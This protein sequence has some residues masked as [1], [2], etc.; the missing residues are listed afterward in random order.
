MSR[1][2]YRILIVDDE[3]ANVYLLSRMLRDSYH[4][5][6]ARGGEEA[7]AIAQGPDKPALI[8]LD[9]MMPEIDGF[10]VCRR[11]KADDNTKDIIV[12]FVT[13]IG[14]SAAEEVG[15]KLGAADYITKPISLPI[16]RARVRNQINM[17]QKADMLEAMSYID[18]LTHVYNRRKF[19]TLL[20]KE[21]QRARLSGKPLGLIMIDFDHF[22]ALND[23]YGHGAGDICLQQGAAALGS[24]LKRQ[25]DLLARYGG[26]EFVALL[27]DTDLEGARVT[28]E[29]MR[30][31]V[32]ELALEH[33][34]S[35]AANHVTVSLG[36]AAVRA[37]DAHPATYLLELADRALNRAKSSGRDR[38]V[39][40][41]EKLDA[42]LGA[43]DVAVPMRSE[44]PLER[45]DSLAVT[46]AGLSP[47]Q[48][49][50]LSAGP[51]TERRRYGARSVSPDEIPQPEKV[52]KALSELYVLPL[53]AELHAEL[54]SLFGVASDLI[55]RLQ[56]ETNAYAS[57][58]SGTQ[59]QADAMPASAGG[60]RTGQL[61]A[62]PGA[63]EPEVAGAD[64]ASPAEA[65]PVENGGVRY[66]AARLIAQDAASGGGDERFDIAEL[67]RRL[68][69]DR[70]IADATIEQFLADAPERLKEMRVLLEAGDLG[71][72]H[73]KG[74]SLKGLAGAVSAPHL[75]E[76][77]EQLEKSAPDLTIAA[78]L[79]GRLQQEYALLEP[80]L[81]GAL[82]A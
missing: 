46:E 20:H 24:A 2:D 19:D 34:Y 51:T 41:D 72:L 27:P 56:T 3:P 37:D 9:V 11:L 30:A 17:R 36:V 64:S 76:L 77:A 63:P 79:V 70:E 52:L 10:E 44:D 39:L 31:A 25:G 66:D 21:W 68:G 12:I 67:M 80:R 62:S 4:I 55:E 33:K 49:S 29:A 78:D 13:A 26:E 71:G 47:L 22:K 32:K 23:H 81:R 16:V 38:A 54:D 50:A 18:G 6:E 73:F 58:L 15:L 28:A 69:D 35:S 60:F 43:E 74:H 65:T 61:Q 48:T 8:L 59:P 53:S 7:L 1:Q 75:Q 14:D 57:R 40:M 82:A 5:S 42:A 45:V